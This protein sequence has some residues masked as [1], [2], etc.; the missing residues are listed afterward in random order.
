MKISLLCVCV[1]V[2]PLSCYVIGCCDHVNA[3]NTK[4][5]STIAHEKT[6][7]NLAEEIS[8]LDFSMRVIVCACVCVLLK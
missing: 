6:K 4:L 8:T 2:K 1:C 5:C 7:T 3:E